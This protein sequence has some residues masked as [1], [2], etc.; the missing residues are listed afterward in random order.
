MTIIEGLVAEHRVFS[1]VFNEIERALP[2]ITTMDE[3]ARLC[4]LLE[5]LLHNHG[6]TEKDL[7]YIAFD[8]IL[9]QRNE[10]IR[11]YHDHQEID[12]LLQEVEKIKDL[13]E[14]RSRFKKA[15]DACRAHFNDEERTVFPLIEKALQHET[16][17]V[18]GRAW[19]SGGR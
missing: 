6:E 13:E 16:L 1:A 8:H 12:V 11:L 7:A 17:L 15:L 19:K 5:A 2:G 18:L 9:K 14:A 3:C 10:L 4:R